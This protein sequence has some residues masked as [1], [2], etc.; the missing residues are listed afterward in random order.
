MKRRLFTVLAGMSLLLSVVTA[1]MLVGSYVSG[2]TSLGLER[3]GLT[4]VDG[5]GNYDLGERTFHGCILENGRLWYGTVWHSN[6][7]MAPPGLFWSDGRDLALFSPNTNRSFSI[8]TQSMSDVDHGVFYEGCVLPIWLI[9]PFGS[10]LPALW[11]MR[12][13]KLNGMSALSDSCRACGYDLRAT[14]DRCPECGTVRGK[15]EG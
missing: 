4:L 15:A 3:R 7:E 8:G 12:F 1:G 13:H 11:L 5:H 2:K 10:V 6:W 14:P 9:I